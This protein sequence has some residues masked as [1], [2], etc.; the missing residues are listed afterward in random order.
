MFRELLSSITMSCGAAARQLGLMSAAVSLGARHRRCR[1]SWEPHLARCRAL[2][3]RAAGS[4]PDRGL[5]VVVG[6]GHL[7]DIPL[8]D[9]A[10]GFERVALADVAHPSVARRAAA[11]FPNVRLVEFDVTGLHREIVRICRDRVRAPLPAPAPPVFP[12]PRPDLLISAN[13]LSQLPLSPAE[14]L[15]KHVLHVEE[16]EVEALS[17]GLI[18]AHLDW[19]RQAADRACLISDFE[20]RVIGDE[21]L[22]SRTDMLHG[23]ALPPG[24]TWEWAIGPRPEAYRDADVVHLVRGVENL[25]L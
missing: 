18:V 17:R 10:K 20:H 11:G 3:G 13:L 25:L 2:I 21:G 22:R 15:R 4:C 1:A 19:L 6:S 12:G 8:A 16:E 5:A 14:S 7:L 24:E 23:V 9:L